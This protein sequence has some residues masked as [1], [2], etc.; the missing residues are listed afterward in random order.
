MSVTIAVALCTHN[1]AAHLREQVRSI[2]AQSVAVD[3]IV[4]GDDASS[5]DTVAIVSEL[6]KESGVPLTVLRSEKPVGVTGN[7]ERA[8][9]ACRSDLVVLSD[10]DDVW[11]PD[12]VERALAV[13]EERPELSLVSSDAELVDAA[14]VS[15]GAGLFE[16]LEIGAPA[17]RDIAEGRAFELYAKRN[18]VTGA[19]TMIRRTLAEAAAPFPSAWI[20]DEWLAIVAAARDEAGVID[21][22]LIDYR[23]HGGNQIGVRKLS[24]AGKLGRM[25]EPGAQR[26]ARLLARA[27][28]LADRLPAVPGVSVERVAATIEKLAHERARSAL[29]VSRLRRV[30]PVL[31]ELRTGRYDRFGRGRAD[32]VRDLLQPLRPA[33]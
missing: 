3:E 1:G 18:L 19:T 5:D 29:P 25:L 12:R 17:L 7:F 24:F 15:L 22:R 13:F 20:H 33:G 4:L 6:V 31:A 2:L 21:E 16:A 26:S 9:L 30:G 8:I 10:Q 28:Q 32:A 23:Q 11:H 27:E 14:G